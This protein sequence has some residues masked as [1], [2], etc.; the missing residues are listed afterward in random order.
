MNTF[1]WKIQHDNIDVTPVTLI[2]NTIKKDVLD[3]IVNQILYYKEHHYK[4]E[5]FGQDNNPG[6]WRGFPHMEQDESKGLTAKN[7]QILF[8]T[9][10]QATKI[11]KQSWP[12]SK[13]LQTTQWQQSLFDEENMDI[14]AWVNV[15]PKGAAN[16][17]HNHSGAAL[18]GVL[19]LQAQ[20]TGDIEFYTDN[21]LHGTSHPTWPYKGTFRHEPKDGDII[22]FPSYLLHAVSANPI[23]KERINMAFNIQYMPAAK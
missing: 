13:F 18:S 2:E 22:L 14:S 3:E 20:G 8:D 10:I 7:K 16:V 11:Y 4:E 1:A 15:N 21:Y 23:D 5:G 12:L 19:Y 17:V 6:C 9:I